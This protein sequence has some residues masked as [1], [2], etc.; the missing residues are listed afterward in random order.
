MDLLAI[1]YVTKW[2][3]FRQIGNSVPPLLWHAVASKI[4]DVVG[5]RAEAEGPRR[6]GGLSLLEFNMS[7]AAAHWGVPA[8]VIPRR[9]RRREAE[10]AHA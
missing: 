8:T 6:M 2:H 1:V 7:N 3:G 9:I 5:S 10:Q 4:M